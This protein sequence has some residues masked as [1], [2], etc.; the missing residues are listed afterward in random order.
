MIT[1]F[2]GIII[3]TIKSYIKTLN[4]RIKRRYKK[5]LFNLILNKVDDITLK[6][7]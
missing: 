3:G 6:N 2:N 4:L 1:N 5:Y 7:L